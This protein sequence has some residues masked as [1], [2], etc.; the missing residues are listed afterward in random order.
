[1]NLAVGRANPRV[2]RDRPKRHVQINYPSC[3]NSNFDEI[4]RQ[5]WLAAV[6]AIQKSD[7]RFHLSICPNLADH[8]CIG[9]DLE[10]VAQLAEAIE[11]EQQAPA[12]V[13]PS[14][15]SFHCMKFEYSGL[16]QWLAAPLGS[17]PAPEIRVDVENHAAVENGL[18]VRPA[19]V[20]TIETDAAS[21]RRNAL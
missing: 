2:S 6:L 1:L 5:Q 20:D 7:L 18:A 12:L 9:K 16:K 15:H 19:I 8:L 17:L 10:W 4:A 11:A 21:H 14:E 3:A 13:L